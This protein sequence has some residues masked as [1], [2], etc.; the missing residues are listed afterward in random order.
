[1]QAAPEVWFTH[2]TDDE[3]DRP[4]LFKQQDP[5]VCVTYSGVDAAV[6]ALLQRV[7]TDPVDAVVGLFEGCLV[8]HLAAARLLRQGEQLPWPCSVFFGDLPIRD[9]SLSK[10]FEGQKAKHQSIHVFGRADE[11]YFNGRR[12]AGRLAPEDYYEA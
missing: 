10:V 8:V 11:Y 12:A 1:M 4:D 2:T 7:S 9:D 5:G 3:R 6:D